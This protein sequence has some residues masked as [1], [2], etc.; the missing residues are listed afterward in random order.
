MVLAEEHLSFIS[1][2]GQ[3]HQ[4]RKVLLQG[5]DAIFSGSPDTREWALGRKDLNVEAFV[6]EFQT[7]KTV[8]SWLRRA[9]NR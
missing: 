6:S 4:V 3:D 1:W 7:L 2:E 9:S 5:A 8:Y